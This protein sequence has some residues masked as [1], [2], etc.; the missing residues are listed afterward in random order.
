MEVR[1]YKIRGGLEEQ[2]EEEAEYDR[3]KRRGGEGESLDDS[4]CDEN[5]ERQHDGD[6]QR[7]KSTRHRAP[8][9]I[10]EVN[11]DLI[12]PYFCARRRD[13][14]TTQRPQAP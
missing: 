13:A 1:G 7:R 2:G 5:Y 8:L 12:I 4:P 14:R 10:G 11:H 9:A 6:G 3:H